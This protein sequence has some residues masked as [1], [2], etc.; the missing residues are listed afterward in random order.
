MENS[1]FTNNGTSSTSNAKLY[2]KSLTLEAGSQLTNKGVADFR[3]SGEGYD[4][5]GSVVVDA[6]SVQTGVGSAWAEFYGSDLTVRNQAED[7]DISFENQAKAVFSGDAQVNN[8]VVVTGTKNYRD[9][10]KA[11]FSAASLSMDNGKFVNG[12]EAVFATTLEGEEPVYGNVTAFNG[13]EIANGLNFELRSEDEAAHIADSRALNLNAVMKGAALTLGKHTEGEADNSRFINVGTAQFTGDVLATDGSHIS[14][15]ILAGSRNANPSLSGLGLT[16]DHASD[17]TN[18]GSAAFDGSVLIDNQSFVE[19]KSLSGTTDPVAHLTGHD[20]TLNEGSYLTNNGSAVFAANEAGVGTGLISAAAGSYVENTTTVKAGS[21]GDQRAVLKGSGLTLTENSYLNNSGVSDFVREDGTGGVITADDHS[22]INNHSLSANL[23]AQLTGSKITLSDHSFLNNTGSA[24]FS[25]E[26][27]D[28]GNIT[29]EKNSYI[30]NTTEFAAKPAELTGAK[31]TL[32]DGSYLKNTGGKVTLS[33][34]IEATDSCV[35]N[36]SEA[37]LGLA[38][39]TASAMGIHGSEAANTHFTNTGSA[40]FGTTETVTGEDGSESEV[41]S[42]GKITASFTDFLNGAVKGEDGE[43]TKTAGISGIVL[44]SGDIELN[45]GSFGNY[46][47]VD[48]ENIDLTNANLHNDTDASVVFTDRFT[49]LA[50]G[51][52]VNRGSIA[53]NDLFELTAL[54]PDGE[55]AVLEN[56]GSGSVAGASINVKR[57]VAGDNSKVDSTKT[58]IVA[59]ESTTVGGDFAL[60]AGSSLDTGKL[61]AA[62]NLA[63]NADNYL[64]DLQDSDVWAK[65][66]R[67]DSDLSI[68]KTSV[69]TVGIRKPAD[70][71]AR[72]IARAAG[73]DSGEEDSAVF[74]GKITNKGKIVTYVDVEQTGSV[75]SDGAL[76][77]GIEIL[78]G[79]VNYTARDV[80]NTAYIRGENVTFNQ[81]DNAHVTIAG[82]DSADGWNWL[83]NSTVNISEGNMNANELGTNGKLGDNVYNVAYAPTSARRPNPDMIDPIAGTDG[84]YVSWGILDK[85]WKENSHQVVLYANSVSREECTVVNVYSG[86][87][88]SV[89]HIQ[90]DTENHDS[91]FINLK[92]GA[93]ETTLG[94]IFAGERYQDVIGVDEPHPKDPSSLVEEYTKLKDGV[95]SSISTDAAPADSSFFVFT[96]NNVLVSTAVSVVQL[97]QDAGYNASVAFSGTNYASFNID[98]ANTLQSAVKSTGDPLNYRVIFTDTVLDNTTVADGAANRTMIVGTKNTEPVEGANILEAGNFGLGFKAVSNADT[99]HIQKGILYGA[100]GEVRESGNQFVLIGSKATNIVSDYVFGKSHEEG[101]PLDSELFNDQTKLLIDA[102]D[103]GLVTVGQESILSLGSPYAMGEDDRSLGWINKVEMSDKAQIWVRKGEFALWDLSGTGQNNIAITDDAILHTDWIK[104][105]ADVLNSNI[106]YVEKSSGTVFNGSVDNRGVFDT[107]GETV[108]GEDGERVTHENTFTFSGALADED[109]VAR[110]NLW[111]QA[112]SSSIHD[113]L[114]LEDGAKVLNDG[115][116]EGKSLIVNDGTS[117][118]NNGT[119]SWNATV[120]DG[121]YTNKGSLALGEETHAVVLT[122]CWITIRT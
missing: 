7:S 86:G 30:T 70:N 64:F 111:N 50:D 3:Y 24:I 84:R 115:S 55:R 74:T 37:S 85:D 113:K 22:Y 13:S 89:G 97:L 95:I 80:I 79:D 92:G 53:G 49:V 122:V 19:N 96:D 82:A 117:V 58:T 114:V 16:L 43:I 73:T 52:S 4:K 72:S 9:S 18:N 36:L 102:A 71:P 88:F 40:I 59:N 51:K 5:A 17:L 31:L 68:D 28:A 12:S 99:V 56:D 107:R 15:V 65:S 38:Q 104:G 101:G 32:S 14:N 119:S 66:A 112:D 61:T 69:F 47:S 6:S 26:A 100:D 98:Q 44:K 77:G 63:E 90:L 83:N 42:R 21:S 27:A 106:L 94:Q 46:A 48:A 39:L 75:N 33:K 29:A 8:S 120:I 121:T 57:F 60:K 91:A 103:G 118:A 93:L 87:V 76:A 10:S 25:G 108:L 23:Q 34:D 110:Y 67:L 11:T 62:A 2:G 35:E 41:F 1:A 81:L 116:F 105:A 20:L 54:N 78:G 45:T 109:G